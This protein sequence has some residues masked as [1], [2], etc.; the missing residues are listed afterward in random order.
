MPCPSAAEE[1]M[2]LC[3]YK[4]ICPHGKDTR[5][6][7]G[8]KSGEDEGQ[9]MWAPLGDSLNA[10]VSLSVQDSCTLYSS[11]YENPPDWG[12]TGLTDR[13]VTPHVMCCEL[14]ADSE[15]GS[16]SVGN[17]GSGSTQQNSDLQQNTNTAKTP[18]T[19]PWSDLSSGTTV[20]PTAAN[21]EDLSVPAFEYA[22]ETY[23]PVP[24][25]RSSGWTGQ[26]Y[27]AVSHH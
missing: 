27:D 24:Y 22:K 5:P 25:N 21:D 26:T 1:S 3:P 15:A 8:H 13:D 20:P 14:N 16:V 6:Y 18:P 9:E 11:M 17:L 2:M 10:W 12:L 23:K 7:G 19:L 4:A